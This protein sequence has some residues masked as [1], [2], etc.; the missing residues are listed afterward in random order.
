M[1]VILYMPEKNYTESIRI[2]LTFSDDQSRSSYGVDLDNE[3]FI[4]PMQDPNQLDWTSLLKTNFEHRRRRLNDQ[5]TLTGF[6]IFCF[7]LGEPDEVKLEKP[8]SQEDFQ[9]GL[10]GSEAPSFRDLREQ[11]Q[12]KVKEYCKRY[13]QEVSPQLDKTAIDPFSS[14]KTPPIEIKT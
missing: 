7:S 8:I 9:R 14:P 5:E 12:I 11:L 13:Q 6:S 10:Q 3:I 4:D 1:Y 2:S